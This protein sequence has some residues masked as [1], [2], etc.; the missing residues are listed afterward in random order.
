MSGASGDDG[1]REYLIE[2]I[3]IGQAVRVAAIDTETGEEV[4][5]Q[6]PKSAAREDMKRL[7]VAKLNRKLG[8]VPDRP[9]KNTRPGDKPGRGIIV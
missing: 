8:I 7:A 4:V 5:I 9:T 2:F 6:A 3:E 1:G